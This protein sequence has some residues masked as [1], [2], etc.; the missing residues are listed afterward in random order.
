LRLDRMNSPA[1]PRMLS[2]TLALEEQSPGTLPLQTMLFLSPLFFR[3]TTPAA[4]S[5]RFLALVL[6]NTRPDSPE[7]RAG[8]RAYAPAAQLLRDALPRMR[9]LAP[10]MFA[11]AATQ[12]A[13]LSPYAPDDSTLYP[14]DCGTVQ[15]RWAISWTPARLR[16]CA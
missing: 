7:L 1:L 12:L 6:R 11:A 10:E 15:T 4:L 3:E 9:K 2:A 5:V 8:A 13:A 14:R 16:T